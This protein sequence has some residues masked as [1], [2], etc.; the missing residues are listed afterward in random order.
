MISEYR[1]NHGLEPITLDPTLTQIATD[2][3]TRMADEDH[4]VH[5]LPG[6]GSLKQRLDA[7]GFQ[8]ATAVENLFGGQ[9]Q[10]SLNDVLQAWEKLPAQN[11]N[12]L[13]ASITT[14]GIYVA[15]SAPGSQYEA[16]WSLILGAPLP[17]A[18]PAPAPADPAPEAAQPAPPAAPAP[19]A[20]GADPA[21]PPP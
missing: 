14:A 1:R 2:H 7:S 15:Y 10:K 4:L 12:L 9:K 21:P 3:A 13:L 8:G 6:E 17:A 20:A 11:A 5:V 16:Y 19:A 18:Q